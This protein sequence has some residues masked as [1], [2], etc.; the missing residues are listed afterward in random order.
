MPKNDQN[1]PRPSP[2]RDVHYESPL[3]AA[4]PVE[5]L[6]RTTLIDRFEPDFFRHPE[7][8]DFHL[9]ILSLDGRGSHWV[10]FVDVDLGPG[11]MVHIYPGQVHRHDPTSRFA[12]LIIL[13]PDSSLEAKQR[14]PFEPDGRVHRWQLGPEILDPVRRV[15]DEIR[16]EQPHFTGS[17]ADRD[18]LLAYLNVLRLQVRRAAATGTRPRV[19][20]EAAPDR[21]R[22]LLEE[23]LL[24]H[25]SVQWFAR[26][27]GCSV[28]TLSRHCMDR[29]GRSPKRVIDDRLS[30]EAKRLLVNSTASAE[31]IGRRLGFAEATHFTRF[32]RR[33]TGD[34]PGRFRARWQG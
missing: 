24:R 9:L 2:I 6:D 14:T 30:L 4:L 5:V 33:T 17:P 29:Y 10:D 25:R 20:D 27:L 22:S 15:V 32:V 21:F 31:S 13:F 11:S 8:V 3:H 23:Q 19:E 18:L 34:P 16:R 7:R 26:E 1:R 12:G 28:R